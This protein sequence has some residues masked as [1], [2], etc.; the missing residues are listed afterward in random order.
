MRLDK[1]ILMVIL[2]GWLG[3]SVFFACKLSTRGDKNTKYM[4]ISILFS[5]I[6]VCMASMN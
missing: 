2:I 3:V 6:A 5:L 1:I 4:F